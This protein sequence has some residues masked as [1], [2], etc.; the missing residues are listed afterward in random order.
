MLEKQNRMKPK[1]ADRKKQIEKN[2][3]NWQSHM[4]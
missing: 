3:M 4:A 1:K 2:R